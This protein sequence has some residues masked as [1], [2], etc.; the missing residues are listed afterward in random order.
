MTSTNRTMMSAVEPEVLRREH[1]GHPQL[2]E[3]HGVRLGD[4]A[5]D[6]RRHR[7]RP[8]Y[9]PSNTRHELH[10]RPGQD[11]DADEVD[12]LGH[13]RPTICSGVNRMPW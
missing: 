3:A 11:R 4:A 2:L 1:L 10:V 9:I 13:G 5:D 12:V 8:G 6:H 7:R